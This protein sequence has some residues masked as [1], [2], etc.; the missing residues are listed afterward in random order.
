MSAEVQRHLFEP[1]FTTKPPGQGTG[2]GLA[3]VYGVVEQAGGFI[4]VETAPGRGAC[5]DVYLPRTDEPVRAA[6]PVA[7]ATGAGGR[8]R[9][10]VVEDDA[11]LREVMV[12]ALRAAGYHAWSAAEADEALAPAPIPDLLLVDAVLPGPDGGAVARALRQRHPGLRVLFT[13]GHPA[14]LLVQ[15]GALRPEDPFLPKPFT[16]GTLLEQVRRV[17]D[18]RP[19]GER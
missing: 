3:T 11:R 15:R 10:L 17:L 1:F 14:E 19:P 2:L 8:E 4:A 18:G 5:F 9:V 7:P 13:S 6:R 12:R 16:P